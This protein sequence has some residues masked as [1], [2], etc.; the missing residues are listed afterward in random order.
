MKSLI[1]TKLN[2]NNTSKFSNLL[3][4]TQQTLSQSL[5]NSINVCR[6]QFAGMREYAISLQLLMERLRT[7]KSYIDIL[8]ETESRYEQSITLLQNNYIELDNMWKIKY[9]ELEY[10]SK[11]K[12][13][14]YVQE[15]EAKYTNLLETTTLA[16][17]ELKAAYDKSR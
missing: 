6:D 14:Q 11:L 1:L 13:D 4:N 7:E 8:K 5:S 2:S 16:Y 15:S 9:Q 3:F 17:S 12:Y 10:T